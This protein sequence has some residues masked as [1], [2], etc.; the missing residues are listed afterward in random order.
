MSEHTAGWSARAVVRLVD[1]CVCVVCLWKFVS[2][3]FCS[4]LCNGLGAPIWRNS[5]QKSPLL[6]LC[7]SVV[8]WVVTGCCAELSWIDRMCVVQNWCDVSCD[9]VGAE[10]SWVYRMCVVQNWCDV[11]CDWVLCRTVM[12]WQ[13]ARCAELVQCELWQCILCRSGELVPPAE[14]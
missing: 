2:T 4:F 14:G 6:L 3:V 10:L 5:P 8:M 12:S 1:V 11:S 9:W 7:R 13:D